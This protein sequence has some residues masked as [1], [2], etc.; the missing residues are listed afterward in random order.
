MVN[1]EK[2]HKHFSLAIALA[3]L[4]VIQRF[5]TPEPI[6]RF[7]VPAFLILT[8]LVTWYNRWY[9]IKIAKYN[10][11]LL[12]RPILLLCA[13][14]GL[15]SVLPSQGVRGLFLIASVLVITFCEFLVGA[16]AENFFVNETL[17][18]AFGIFCASAAF[19]QYAPAFGIY[20]V[21][22]L[23]AG[24]GLL[25]RSFYEFLPVS[26]K[27]KIVGSLMLALFSAEVFWALS[28]LQFHFS[29]LAFILFSVF[30]FLMSVSYYHIFQTLSFKKIQFHLY[31]VSACIILVLISTP[32]SLI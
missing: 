5:A 24:V 32:W 28:F 31:L 26:G 8:A 14:F 27:T 10:F 19:Y 25:S 11:W 21:I 22:G 3:F 7:L 1:P 16:T 15:F 29:A 30:Y 4:L 18:I 9:L 13:A 17:L 2:H 12:L 6:F 23:F 20:Y